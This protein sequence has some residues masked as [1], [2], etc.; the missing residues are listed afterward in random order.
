[1]AGST[2]A[3]A[4]FPLEFLQGLLHVLLYCAVIGN[5]FG[6]YQFIQRLHLKR[7]KRQLPKEK[8]P[9]KWKYKVRPHRNGCGIGI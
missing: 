4:D 1:M 8:I 3:G 2:V 5:I 6:C 9:S 7:E